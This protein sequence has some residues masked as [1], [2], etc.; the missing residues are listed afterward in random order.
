MRKHQRLN[1][2]NE[3]RASAAATRRA[4]GTVSVARPYEPETIAAMQLHT[5]LLAEA[6]AARSYPLPRR[7]EFVE[8]VDGKVVATEYA[9]QLLKA[10]VS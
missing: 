7:T 1:T 6:Y 2:Y 3:E 10:V 9:R 4:Q 8:R 5:K